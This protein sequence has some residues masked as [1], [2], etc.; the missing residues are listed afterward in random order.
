[1]KKYFTLILLAILPIVASAYDA[2][3]DGIY[4]NFSE[5]EATVTYGD[6]GYA[7]AVVIPSSVTYND[8]TYNV[9]SIGNFAFGGCSGLTSVTIPESVTDIGEQAFSGCNGLTSVTIPDLAAWCSIAFAGSSSN[10]L[11]YAHHLYMNGEEI[12]NLIIPSSVTSIGSY[13]FS[14]CTSLTSV[15]IPEG[16]SSIGN[17]AFFG[18]SGLTSVTIP[19]SVTSIESGTFYNC[20]S[21][22]SFA[23]P[24]CVTSIGSNAFSGCIGLTSITIPE[25]VTSI[26]YYA[27]YK[28]YFLKGKFVNN[29]TL[30][31][32]NNWG[33][34]L[35]DEETCDG[36]L[37]KDNSVVRYRPWVTSVTIPNNVTSISNWAFSGCT[38]LTSVTI[39]NSV[40]RIGDCAF[41]NC[42]GLNS[43]TIPNSVTYIGYHAF[44]DCSGLSSITIG[45]GAT[46]IGEEAFSGC[47]FLKDRYVNHSTLTSANNWGAVLIDEETLDGLLIIDNTVV[48]YR[49]WVTSVTIPNSVTSIGFGAFR[50][51][52]SLTEVT[53]GNSVTSIDHWAFSSCIGLTSVTIGNGVTCISGGAFFGCIGLTSVTIPNSVTSIES[54]AFRDCS[55]LTSVIIGDGVTNIGIEAFSSCS[56][57]TDFWCLAENVPSA[58]SDDSDGGTFKET[59]IKRATLHVPAT[60]IEQYKAVSPWCRFGT[61]VA[62]ME[63]KGDLNGDGKVDIADAVCV[64]DVMA[65]DVYDSKAD[66]NEDGKIDIADFVCVLDIMAQQ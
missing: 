57:L 18:C 24:N 62:I 12:R 38:G 37:I 60:S 56:K 31:N 33:A 66:L 43:V 59:H 39:P 4:Y 45:S 28:C 58:W 40:T 22:N 27:F 41:Q 35:I 14:G 16:V 44:Y 30:T 51:C 19:E 52:S 65:K 9:T 50:D 11:Y 34:V 54:E 5:N 25:S 47:Y 48:G 61:I 20:S 26:G 13:A 17:S 53:I 10:P 1:M 49:P 23:I 21:L 7:G 8:K 32:T 63:V 55:G 6:D 3:I 2:E 29:S 46:Y 15:S 42:S 64:L 36:L